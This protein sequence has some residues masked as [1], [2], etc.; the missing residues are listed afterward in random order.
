VEAVVGKALVAAAQAVQELQINL[1][2]Q[3]Q[4]Q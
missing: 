4:A 3:D 2:R 1:H